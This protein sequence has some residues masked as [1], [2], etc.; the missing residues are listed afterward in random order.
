MLHHLLAEDRSND[1]SSDTHNKM[2]SMRPTHSPSTS[3]ITCPEC[4]HS[5]PLPPGYQQATPDS[6]KAVLFTTW[7]DY[8]TE[9]A[10]K[11]SPYYIATHLP[12]S[13]DHNA[14]L[15]HAAHP[16]PN[17]YLRTLAPEQLESLKLQL[18]TNTTYGDEMKDRISYTVDAINEVLGDD[19]FLGEQMRRSLHNWTMR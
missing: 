17:R 7:G 1:R 15:F 12:W 19:D 14:L 11:A 6:S 3:L 9:E 2:R 18:T 13:G 8:N 10:V 5:F 16:V 4:D